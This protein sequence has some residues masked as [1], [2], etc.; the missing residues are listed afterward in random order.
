[1]PAPKIA[2]P[3]QRHVRVRNQHSF[4]L[5]QDYVEAIYHRIERG[6]QAR[7]TDLQADF[8]VSHV[9]VIRALRRLEGQGLLC[10][11]RQEGISL[12]PEGE[13]MARKA[14]E[15]HELLVRLFC[16]L[17]VS[18]GQA[19]ADAEGGEHHL[20]QETLDAISRFLQ[21]RENDGK[22]PTAG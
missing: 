1:M 8:G 10:Y 19:D 7:V 21:Q 17:G 13:S 14:I 15:R 20:S 3:A 4:E 6:D 5:A 18:H 16:A 12:T 9:S 11:S 22:A 2:S